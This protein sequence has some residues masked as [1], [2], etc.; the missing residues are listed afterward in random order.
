MNYRPDEKKTLCSALTEA[1]IKEDLH[2]CEAAQLLNLNPCYIQWAKNEK[3]FSDISL[4]AWERFIQWHESRG[5]IRDFKI[6]EGEPIWQPK[7]K[8][9]PVKAVEP[10]KLKLPLKPVKAV[11]EVKRQEVNDLADL[12][13]KVKFL[14]DEL[15][16]VKQTI[17]NIGLNLSSAREPIEKLKTALLEIC[18]RLDNLEKPQG[19]ILPQIKP[20]ELKLSKI[21]SKEFERFVVNFYLDRQ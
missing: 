1:I 15:A 5:R 12:R 7:V 8:A 20:H 13:Q 2:N 3:Y 6:P 19:E 11:K 21:E 18:K 9:V 17:N 10:L 16:G 4:A 14:E